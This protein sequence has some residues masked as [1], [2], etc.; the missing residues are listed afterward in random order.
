MKSNLDFKILGNENRRKILKILSKKPRYVTELS[1]ILDISRKAVI[2]HLAILEDSG[3]IE[4]F[5]GINRRKYYKISKS[6]TFEYAL[7]PNTTF[8]RIE[9]NEVSSIGDLE[10]IEEK[11][12]R[13]KI[14]REKIS[15]NADLSKML[16]NLREIEEF[17]NE[18]Q[19]LEKYL[20]LL[21]DKT[22]EDCQEGVIKELD[23]EGEREM[24]IE[25]IRNGQISP[26]K[27]SKKLDIDLN[28]V[29]ELFN[30]LRCRDLI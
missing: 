26:E 30:N 2:D 6:V 15:D 24:L 19:K 29:Y 8:T 11:F 23:K 16:S 5:S 21:I 18:V 4:N 25:I 7:F 13:A 17:Y 10:E 22:I 20:L 27:L 14:L 3:L 1:N 12:K 28:E 9:C